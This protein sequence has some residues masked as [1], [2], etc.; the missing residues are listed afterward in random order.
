MTGQRRRWMTSNM[1]IDT[2][3]PHIQMLFEMSFPGLLRKTYRIE[4]R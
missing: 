4:P 1:F 2:S 3:N